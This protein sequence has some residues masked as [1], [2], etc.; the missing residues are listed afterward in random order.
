[1]EWASGFKLTIII[2]IKLG[3][4]TITYKLLYDTK[5]IKTGKE[6]DSLLKL[7]PVFIGR[8]TMEFKGQVGIVTGGTRGIGKAIAE[9]LAKEGVN[10]AIAGRNL[11]AAKE[12][13]ATLTASGIKAIGIRLDVSNSAEV[14]KAFEEVEKEFNRIY[15]LINNA[16][17][18]KDGL[19]LRMKDEDWDSVMDINLKGVF[20]CSREAV[21][22]MSGQRYGRIVN[23]TSVAAFMGNPGQANYSASK[24]GIVGFTKT[25]AREYAGRG[26]TANAVA[27]GFIQT[28]MTDVLSDKI[29]EEM[30]KMIPLGRF[31]IVEDVVNAVVFLA[32]PGSGYITGQVIHVNGGMYM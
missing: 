20:L 17:I 14:I 19:L 27:P 29:K 25:I 24:A 26:V 3:N 4:N 31:G 21:K 32:S 5:T 13:A 10:L 11:D 1:M 22:V 6:T 12:V 23:I 8:Y 15:I 30:K 7:K 28:A 9:G 16:G 2:N 18:T